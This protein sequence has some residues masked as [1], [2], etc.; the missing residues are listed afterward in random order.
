MDSLFEW[1]MGGI[2]GVIITEV[3]EH[4]IKKSI[5]ELRKRHEYK[6]YSFLY[7]SERVRE[8][9]IQYYEKSINLMIS[10]FAELEMYHVLF[11]I[12]HKALGLI[13]ALMF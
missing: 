6:K 9:L 7:S 4:L 13:S 8:K 2:I 10:M 5:A 3:Y 11:Y 12:P 1:I